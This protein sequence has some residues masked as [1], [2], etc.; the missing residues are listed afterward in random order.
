MTDRN[1]REQILQ[2]ARALFRE[3]GYHATTIRDIADEAGM[4]SGSLYAH[5]R[6]KEDLLFEITDEIADQFLDEMKAV[7][8]RSLPPDAL[9]RQGLAAHL[10]VV[11]THL[12]AASVFMHEWRGLSPDRRRVIQEKRDAY[13]QMWAGILEAGAAAGVFRREGLRFARLVVL[14]V[15]NWS[16]QWL[17][18]GGVLSAE[19]LA[20]QLAEVLLSG[21]LVPP[22]DRADG[23]A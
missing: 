1:R 18:P 11:S 16:Y 17:H 2:A 5:I 19:Q 13:E 22:A 10:R 12:D 8:G 23:T 21:L 7:A 6:T 20:D 3:K 15:A 9:L 4:L 14:S